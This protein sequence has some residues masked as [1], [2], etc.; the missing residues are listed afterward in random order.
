MSKTSIAVFVI[1]V[2]LLVAGW[3]V[4]RSATQK[5]GIS[6]QESACL[7]SGDCVGSEG[8]ETVGVAEEEPL[9]EQPD[10]TKFKEYFTSAF[11]AKLPAEAEF[12][13]FEVVRTKIFTAQ[14]Q[15]C[16]SLELKKT[17]PSGSLATAVYDTALKDYAQPKGGFPME[18][19]KG[20]SIG[21]EPLIYPAGKY[22]YK[23]Y[24]DDILA[25]VL[26]FEVR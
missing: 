25:V 16:T 3:L 15:F 12:N 5:E 17:I 10:Q 23:I 6:G 2:A 24:I 14:D 22:E 26:P 18:L 4:Y 20:G 21:C 8:A 19:K 13:P 11:L 7:G 9:S 1:A